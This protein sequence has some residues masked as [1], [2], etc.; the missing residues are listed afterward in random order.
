S[1]RTPRASTGPAASA[2]PAGAAT[3]P[4]P[5]RTGRCAGTAPPAA[6]RCR[7]RTT[8]CCPARWRLRPP[9]A[10]G[11]SPPAPCPARPPVPWAPG[12]PGTSRASPHNRLTSDLDPLPG[13]GVRGALAGRG[14]AR[15]PRARG[16][17]RV[18]RDVAPDALQLV[19]APLPAELVARRVLQVRPLVT[20]YL[21]G[22]GPGGVG[23]PQREAHRVH[24]P[25]ALPR[26]AAYQ[27]R[28]AEVDAP[29]RPAA[30]AASQ[31]ADQRRRG[32]RRALR[33]PVHRR[34]QRPTEHVVPGLRG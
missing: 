26:G 27:R 23:D 4:G 28:R 20:Q 9:P 11:R 24:V 14:S 10:S 21:D 30:G 17:P 12:R 3:G 15:P 1:A 13:S 19:Q 8:C 29:G 22:L 7:G 2:D 32:A 16:D 5:P 6:G 34:V 31:P 33:R 25:V 18:R